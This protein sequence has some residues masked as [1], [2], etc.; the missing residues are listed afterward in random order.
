[1]TPEQVNQAFI[2]I[3]VSHQN[4]LQRGIKLRELMRKDLEN[5]KTPSGY[6][7]E[8]LKDSAYKVINLLGKLAEDFD[9]EHPDDRYSAGDIADVVAT[10]EMLIK[11]KS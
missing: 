1:M 7:Y 9:N 3:I 2:N 10:V 4:R 11:T 5:G 8:Y 6:R